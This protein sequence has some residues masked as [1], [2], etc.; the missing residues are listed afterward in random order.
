MNTYT[1]NNIDLGSFGFIA[2]K[3]AGSNI[4]LS[5]VFDMP[6]RTGKTF[7]SWGDDHGVEPYVSA[8]EISFG[9]RTISL[10][11]YLYG[12]GKIDC[13]YKANR[14]FNLINGFSGLVPLSSKWG[15]YQVQV[16]Q[17]VTGD[18]IGDKVLKMTFNFFEPVVTMP[19]IIPAG[20][21][22]EYGIDGIS[23]RDLGGVLLLLTGDRASRPAPKSLSFTSKTDGLAEIKTEA[24]EMTLKLFIDQPDQTSFKAKIDELCLLF[25]APGL[26][27]LSIPT[28]LNRQFFV[29]DGFKVSN[30]NSQ[31]NRMTG[32]LECKITESGVL[33]SYANLVDN[34]G[35]KITSGLNNL[36]KIR[37]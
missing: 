32:I 14:I 30:I 28:D 29:K 37:I 23:F 24:R 33:E 19:G 1:L 31:P 11:G 16:N 12:V 25:A 8:T 35:Q 36:I 26:R 34:T 7:Q 18:F 15:T 9:G 21:G 2:G 10:V 13:T 20:T 5:G 4:A 6:P 3:Q 17:A 27:K 22:A